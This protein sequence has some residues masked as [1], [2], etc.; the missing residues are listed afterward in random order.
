MEDDEDE[1][2]I[3]PTNFG[4]CVFQARCENV[5]FIEISQELSDIMFHINNELAKLQV[6]I[7]ESMDN[8]LGVSVEPTIRELQTFSQEINMFY[9]TVAE[10]TDKFAKLPDPSD[11]I[12]SEPSSDKDYS[13]IQNMLHE[14][15]NLL[16]VGFLKR[17]FHPPHTNFFR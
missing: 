3:L 5:E 17:K 2:M 16:K 9:Q 1:N 10:Y 11:A 8:E 12:N 6:V 7:F 14:T 4:D 13:K 15:R